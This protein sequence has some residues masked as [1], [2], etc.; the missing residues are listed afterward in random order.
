M[1][2]LGQLPGAG[3]SLHGWGSYSLDVVVDHRE[4]RH[5]RVVNVVDVSVLEALLGCHDGRTHVRSQKELL[6][7]LLVC[8][9]SIGAVNERYK[10]LVR[11]HYGTL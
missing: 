7:V 3:S 4:S 1:L 5:W 11:L 6:L 8:I 10:L 9:V 2:I